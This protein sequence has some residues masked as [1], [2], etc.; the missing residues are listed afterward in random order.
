MQAAASYLQATDQ[1]EQL[2]GLP[3]AEIEQMNARARELLTQS[4][5]VLRSRLSQYARVAG[6]LDEERSATVSL[7]ENLAERVAS[8]VRDQV[9]GAAGLSFEQLE[10]E[11]EVAEPGL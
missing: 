8:T 10:R 11:D 9:A 7:D 4:Q 6:L 2:S 1:A 5:P 3:L